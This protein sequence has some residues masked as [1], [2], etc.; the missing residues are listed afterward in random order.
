MN[1]DKGAYSG[2]TRL[3]SPDPFSQGDEPH[4]FI[5]RCIALPTLSKDNTDVE[6]DGPIPVRIPCS[7]LPQP[8]S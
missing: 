6:A 2:T 4:V 8:L 1:R 7:V 3:T 5:Q